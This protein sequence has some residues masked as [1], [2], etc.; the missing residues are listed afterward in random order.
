[1]RLRELAAT[2]V[3]FGYRRLTELL[4]REGWP[5]RQTDLSA[6]F[7]GRVNGTDQNADKTGHALQQ[8]DGA[9][10]RPDGEM[11]HGFCE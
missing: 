10:H 1:M 5:E 4:R 3:R 9:I 7:E 8:H 2:R 6:L 11:E